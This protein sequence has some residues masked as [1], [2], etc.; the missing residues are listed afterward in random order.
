MISRFAFPSVACEWTEAKRL[1]SS[2]NR[3]LLRDD[4]GFT[5]MLISTP[6]ECDLIVSVLSI[7]DDPFALRAVLL[8]RGR[9]Y[10]SGNV[11][12]YRRKDIIYL[13]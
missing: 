6:S 9:Q 4:P 13:S 7:D 1:P 5:F 11:V 2:R 8:P 10:L 3:M 12:I